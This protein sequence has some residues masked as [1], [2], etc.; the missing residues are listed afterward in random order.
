MS[1]H[2]T[3][4]TQNH[5]TKQHN[6]TTHKTPQNITT[7]HNIQH[8]ITQY[9]KHNTTQHTDKHEEVAAVKRVTVHFKQTSLL[10]A[11]VVIRVDDSLTVKASKE[12]ATKLQHLITNESD[13]KQAEIHLDLGGEEF[14][15]KNNQLTDASMNMG[16]D[17]PP[18]NSRGENEVSFAGI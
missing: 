5:A 6:T 13:V 14:M 3:T 4:Q 1:P 2:T 11:E 9:L 16:I 8:N 12:L 15:V 7:H 17:M 18:F 10:T